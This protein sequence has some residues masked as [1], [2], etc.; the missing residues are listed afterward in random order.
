MAQTPEITDEPLWDRVAVLST[1]SPLDLYFY[2]V[3]QSN[4]DPNDS[5]ITKALA[6]TNM[7]QQGGRLGGDESFNAEEIAIMPDLGGKQADAE[8][9]AKDAVVEILTENGRTTAWRCPARLIPAGIG[10]HGSSAVTSAGVG[11]LGFPS[12]SSRIKFKRPIYISRGEAFSV[13]YSFKAVP[14]LSAN[15]KLTSTLFGDHFMVPVAAAP[16]APT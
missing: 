14:S 4:T 5:T 6:D 16:A 2:R 9:L 3:P 11:M 10:I 7:T 15:C 13:K 8:L 1:T 12:P